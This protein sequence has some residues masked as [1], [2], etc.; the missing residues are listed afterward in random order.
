MWVSMELGRKVVNEFS[1]PRKSNG[2][3]EASNAPRK[4][5]AVNHINFISTSMSLAGIESTVLSPAKTSHALIPPEE[6]ERLGISDQLIRFSLGIE[7]DQDLIA[8]IE[9]ALKKVKMTKSLVNSENY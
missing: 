2:C 7:D 1:S 9:Q 3:G 8:D 5:M 6:R 4:I